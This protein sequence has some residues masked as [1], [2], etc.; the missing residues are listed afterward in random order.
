MSNHTIQ[1]YDKLKKEIKLIEEHY[2]DI[3]Y[4]KDR[5]FLLDRYVYLIHRKQE[6]EKA[7]AEHKKWGTHRCAC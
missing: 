5:Q 7:F 1:H 6:M 2:H 3:I 4:V